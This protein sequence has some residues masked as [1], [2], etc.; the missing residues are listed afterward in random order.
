ML[1]IDT[2]GD[3]LRQNPGVMKDRIRIQ[4][5]LRDIFPKDKLT[6]NLL[7]MGFEENIFSLLGQNHS[8][9]ELTRLANAIVDN[10]GVTRENANYIVETWLGSRY[11]QVSW[12]KAGYKGIHPPNI[13]QVLIEQQIELPHHGN[14]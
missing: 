11:H 4:S 13:T 14:I 3:Y 5:I 7:L 2:L 6:V 8:E 1:D 12:Q 9:A 10:Y